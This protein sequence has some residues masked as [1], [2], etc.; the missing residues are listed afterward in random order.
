MIEQD[1]TAIAVM[2]DDEMAGKGRKR[3]G[4]SKRGR[5]VTYYCMAT[6]GFANSGELSLDVFDFIYILT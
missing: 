3:N 4:T 2:S 6:V 1:L 5:R